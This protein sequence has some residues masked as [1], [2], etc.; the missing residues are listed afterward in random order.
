VT[1]NYQYTK[2]K[3]LITRP[4]HKFFDLL[5]QIVGKN[6]YVFPQV[7]ISSFL[8]HKFNKQNLGGAFAHIHQKSVD[9][10]ICDKNYIEPVLAI[11]LDDKSHQREDRVKRD[12][13]VNKLLHESNM[14]LI[15]FENHGSF[16]KNEITQRLSKVLELT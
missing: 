12:T 8:D 7:S 6:Y 16:D 14:P 1:F 3:F 10:V 2:K 4:E 13:D 11:E 5:I 9:F 15:R